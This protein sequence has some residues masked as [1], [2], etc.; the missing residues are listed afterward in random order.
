MLRETALGP[1]KT[2]GS[3]LRGPVVGPCKTSSSMFGGYRWAHARPSVVCC[4]ASTGP[5][6]KFIFSALNSIWA[7]SRHLQNIC[8]L[9]PQW[10][11]VGFHKHDGT[12]ADGLSHYHR[13][14]L[15]S[16]CGVLDLNPPRNRT[17]GTPSPRG[18]RKCSSNISFAVVSITSLETSILGSSSSK[19]ISTFLK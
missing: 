5:I 10:A 13:D 18:T 8:T 14:F 3:M 16:L 1:C 2:I 6:Q 17:Q 7:H 11:H 15:V 19:S 4:G 9:G 12:F